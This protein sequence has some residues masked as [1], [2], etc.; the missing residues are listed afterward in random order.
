MASALKTIQTRRSFTY[1]YYFAAPV[2][3]KPFLFLAHGFP[4]NHRAWR[5]Q[6]EFFKS[7][8]YGLVVPDML[9]YGNSSKPTDPVAYIG[10]G[11]A[12]DMLD[13]LDKEGIQ[14]V[15][16]IAHD[17]G[18]RAASRFMNFHPERVSAA[19]FLCVGYQPPYAKGADWISMSPVLA[20]LAGYDIIGYM[21]WFAGEEAARVIDG[22]R[23]YESLI[24]MCHPEKPEL[25]MESFCATD[26]ARNWI[27]ENTRTDLPPYMSQEDFEY[28]VQLLR[29]GGIAAP[30]C[31]YKVLVTAESAEDDEK[32]L[33]VKATQPILFIGF[34]KDVVARPEFARAV[35]Q[36]TEKVVGKVTD[37]EVAADHWGMESHP[38][39]VN[40]YILE[41]LNE[42]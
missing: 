29:E 13:I 30:F 24:N 2:D 39:E 7:R 5:Y 12:G 15:I 37:R 21:R 25:W 41:W 42:L 9:G 32:V 19:A 26:G 31:W 23:R 18:S 16:L 17:W 38:Q 36:D 33:N 6:I 4:G 35:H 1:S 11:L 3:S 28:K 27:L 8:G 20:Q 40:N 22:E 10:S 14:Q 34:N